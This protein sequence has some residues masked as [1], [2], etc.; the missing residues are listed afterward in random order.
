MMGSTIFQ[1]QRKKPVVAGLLLV[2]LVDIFTFFIFFL[3]INAGDSAQ[4][5]N[6]KYV[7]LPNSI[8]NTEPRN[9]VLIFIDAK[10]V[11]LGDIVVANVADI[12]TAP[13]KL[14]DPLTVAL[15]NHKAAKGELSEYEKINGLSITI[16]GDK[17]VPYSLLKSVM[18]TCQGSDY[19]NISLAVNHVFPAGLSGAG[20]SPDAAVNNAVKVG[21]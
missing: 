12:L 10:Q 16:M 5:Q 20:T 3:L 11:W 19:R 18:V 21:G 1:I 2:S 15:A 6:A 17:S 14:I 8:S 7:A 4:I 13:E 9:K